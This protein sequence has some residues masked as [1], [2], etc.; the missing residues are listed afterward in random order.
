MSD[1]FYKDLW[2][3][4]YKVMTDYSLSCPYHNHALFEL[5]YIIDNS[6]IHYFGNEADKF[7]PGQY[8]IVD[9]AV[10]HR[11]KS[12]N[13]K[14][15][16]IIN[17]LFFPEFLDSSLLGCKSFAAMMNNYLMRFSSEGLSAPEFNRIFTDDGSIRALLEECINEY[18][19]KSPGFTEIIRC[20]LIKIILHTMRKIDTELNSGRIAD[21]VINEIHKDFHTGITLSSIAKRLHFSLP[22]IS[23]RF[24]AETGMTFCEALKRTRV[25]AAC[26]YIATSNK[27]MAEIASLSGFTDQKTFYKAFKEVMGITPGAFRNSAK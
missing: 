4:R 16:G 19:L 13:G 6:G 2:A 11:Y 8:F 17:F 1:V 21:I 9:Y 14:K 10:K 23:T 27:K 5:G 7:K 24:K 20:N 12:T 22:Y 18:T 25:E 3:N 26:R 15:I